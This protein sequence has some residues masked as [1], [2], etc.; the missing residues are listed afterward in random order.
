[1]G[2]LFSPPSINVPPPP[3]LPPA[4]IPPTMANPS[5]QQAGASQLA[6]GAGGAY[7]GT[8]KTSGQGDLVKPTTT[9]AALLGG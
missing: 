5:V 4:A 3:P 9:E 2:A 8:V 6:R 1:M 7:G